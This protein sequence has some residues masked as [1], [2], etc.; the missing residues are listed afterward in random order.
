MTPVMTPV[1]TLVTIPVIS[2][3]EFL[4]ADTTVVLTT[5]MRTTVTLTI[6]MPIT[7]TLTILIRSVIM[8][9]PV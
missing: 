6:A 3:P 7:A 4:R 2:L 8:M 5:V 1:M 9:V